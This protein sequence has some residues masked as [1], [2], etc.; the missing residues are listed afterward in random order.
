MDHI[1][2]TA[3]FLWHH[4]RV[5]KLERCAAVSQD[6][7]TWG[8]CHRKMA[9][10]WIRSTMFFWTIMRFLIT[11]CSGLMMSYSALVKQAANIDQIDDVSP[12]VGVKVIY[13]LTMA[14]WWMCGWLTV[15][16]VVS[17]VLCL[18]GS[19]GHLLTALS[20]ANTINICSKCIICKL[21]SVVH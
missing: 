5:G 18:P 21:P 1:H 14:P 11:C 16:Q 8:W 12:P 13:T 19:P 3:I 10:V 17:L 20:D 15:Q 9:A 6:F 4:T 7:L 2:T